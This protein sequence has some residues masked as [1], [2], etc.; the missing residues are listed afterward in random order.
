MKTYNGFLPQ[1]ADAEF[2]LGDY[3]YFKDSVWY[4][5]GNIKDLSEMHLRTKNSRSGLFSNMIS[6]AR[7]DAGIEAKAEIADS[8]IG[9]S[10]TFSA[11]NGFFQKANLD[12]FSQYA[13]VDEV[14]ALLLD[15]FKN[16]RWKME[17]VLTACI[18]HASSFLTIIS[19]SKKATVG[20]NANL[21]V[22]ETSGKFNIDGDLKVSGDINKTT[23]VIKQDD[24]KLHVSAA[25]FLRLTRSIPII[26]SPHAKFLGPVRHQHI[27]EGDLYSPKIELVDELD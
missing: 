15:L 3:G 1:P 16:N 7:L 6:E 20:V 5:L 9:T 27:S 26:S 17:Y 14:E 4:R 10:I 12:H 18:A 2:K 24:G 8:G 19:K 21:T 23:V 11:K 13:S 22:P 25:K